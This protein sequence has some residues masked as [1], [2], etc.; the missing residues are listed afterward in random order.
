MFKGFQD[1]SIIKQFNSVVSNTFQ[2][3]N[4]VAY[5]FG[6]V[7]F[8]IDAA[9]GLNTQTNLSAV[10]SWQPRIGSEPFIQATAGSQPR[11][12]L[13][14]ANFNNLPTIDAIGSRFL[15]ARTG[16]NLGTETTILWVSKANTSRF[17]NTIIAN[18][19]TGYLIH[20]GGSLSGIN[21]VGL[22]NLGSNWQGTT[23]TTNTEIKVISKNYV[24]V[25]GTT[26]TSGLYIFPPTTLNRIFSTN[27]NDSNVGSIAE[28]I[29]F[30]YTLTSEQAVTL[31]NRLNEKYA[32]Y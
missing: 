32:V 14:D 3:N 25:N 10:S 24:M 22:Y 9:Y 15:D 2:Q 17:L 13:T 29:A 27:T 1:T 7:S 28:I 12:I 18:S 5:G 30:N 21:G 26:Q 31:S 11:L 23:E 20:D 19:T 16:L 8:W 4:N 6:G